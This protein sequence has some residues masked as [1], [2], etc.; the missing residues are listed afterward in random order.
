MAKKVREIK[1]KAYLTAERV[2]SNSRAAFDL[3]SQSRLGE[4]VD[5]K[6]QYSLVEALYLLEK[7]KL[8]IIKDKKAQ[9]RCFDKR[10]P[11][12]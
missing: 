4:P 1:I 12:D 5:G 11:E 8:E 6:I 9:S 3:Y 7:G 10:S 2:S